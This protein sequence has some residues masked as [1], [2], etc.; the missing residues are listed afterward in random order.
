MPCFF[1]ALLLCICAPAHAQQFWTHGA[2]LTDMFPASDRVEPV[3]VDLDA[4]DLTDFR[5]ALGYKAPSAQYTVYVARTGQQVDGI[6]LFDNQV[7]QHEPITFAV[8]LTPAGA[9]V[10]QEVVTYRE[11]Y[12]DEVR[13]GRFRAQFEGKTMGDAVVAGDD[14]KIVAGATYSSRSMAVG[15]KRVLWLGALWLGREQTMSAAAP[16]ARSQGPSALP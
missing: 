3:Y 11:K 16:T 1:A 12:G 5:E 9:V 14:I 8:Q 6:A 2:L 15:V 10:R 7:G 4:A 13:H